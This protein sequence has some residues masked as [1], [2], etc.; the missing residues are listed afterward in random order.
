VIGARECASRCFDAALIVAG[1]LLAVTATT[2]L[3]LRWDEGGDW[4]YF[5]SAPFVVLL[6]YFPILI[7]R[8][9]GGIEIALDFCV[10]A[11]LVNTIGFESA[12]GCWEALVVWC[13]GTVACQ[14]LTDKRLRTKALNSALG[15]VAGGLAVLVITSAHTSAEAGAQRNLWATGAGAAVYFLVD[16]WLSVTSLSLAQG[17]S[18]RDELA[19]TGALMAFVA[20]LAISSLGLLAAL[21]VK[22]LPDWS[23]VMLV[24]P[25]ATILVAS[26]AL[27]RG[28]EHARRLTLFL[29][30]AVTTQLVTDRASLSTTLRDAA[31]DLLRDPLVQLREAPPD[32]HEIGVAVQGA[33]DVRWIVAPARNRPRSTA[34]DD[35]AGLA[36][37]VAVVED[38]FIRIGLS[39]EITHQAWHDPL[40]GL[41]NRSLF[42]DRV[43]HALELQRLRGG[44]LAVLVC[45]LD[46][47][48]RINDLFG[49]AAGDDLLV[50]VGERIYANVREIDTV[51]RLGGDEF[52][53]L[54]EEVGAQ[55]EAELAAERILTAL[56][57]PF[58]LSDDEVQVTTTIGV[59]R[60]ETAQT[61]DALVS[62]ADLAMSHGKRQGKDRVS[63]YRLSFGD[64]RLEGIKLVD[65]LR[66]AVRTR[67]FEVHYQPVVDLRSHVITGVEALV[68]WRRNGS[69]VLPDAFIPAAEESGLMVQLGDFVLDTVVTDAP[70]LV[71]AAGGPL[72]IA[73]NVSAQE[74]QLEGFADRIRAA[75]AG[76]GGAALV[77]E[78]TE[79]DFVTDD[80]QTVAAM[81]ALADIGVQFAID[82]FG[83][84]FSSIDYL[85]RLPVAILKIDKSFVAHIEEDAKACRLVR[86]MVQMGRA[87]GVDVVVEG[88]ERWGQ[89]EHVTR[90]SGAVTAQ[91]FLFGRPLPPAQTAVCL[92]APPQR[93]PAIPAAREVGHAL[94]HIR[95]IR[96]AG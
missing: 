7:G 29:D 70:A 91:G 26:R 20:F 42:M 75:V 37:L 31:S 14:A 41:A 19:P 25:I 85:Q 28:G 84:G 74:L 9:G 58:L 61:A 12:T 44:E 16:F 62:Q 5:L 23:A 2:V 10:L 39:E 89:V 82:D 46:A 64:E 17:T 3:V 69:L 86:S 90:H 45:D 40:T 11:F 65:G 18:L 36:A 92:A 94:A 50:E 35:Q 21:V 51:A 47:F 77:V 60:S 6:G 81:N 30:T 54:L 15:T 48:K 33:D 76:M 8:T 56:Q 4:R 43:G 83:V 24:V 93:W 32:A 38:S 52:A 95:S 22:G 87:L 34:A 63:T 72:S 1:T 80:P 66:A 57:A 88:I 96:A 68:R 27:S 71:A 55:N 79:R 78:V 59:A 67:S 73:V 49:H 53:V 13:A